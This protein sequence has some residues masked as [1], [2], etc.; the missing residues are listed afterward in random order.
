MALSPRDGT[1]PGAAMTPI[2]RLFSLALYAAMVMAGAVLV[3][4]FLAGAQSLAALVGG[5]LLIFGVYLIRMDFGPR[6][7]R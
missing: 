5:F 6:K 3:Y 4:M 1:I 2:R 7:G